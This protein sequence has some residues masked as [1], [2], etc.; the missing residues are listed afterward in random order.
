LPTPRIQRRK[1]PK[2]PRVPSDEELKRLRAIFEYG[3]AM[4]I[5]AKA[6][7]AHVRLP[8]EL[9]VRRPAAATEKQTRDVVLEQMDRVIEARVK[10]RLK[11]AGVPYTEQRP[12]RW[13]S[14]RDRAKAE[15]RS[16]AGAPQD[17]AK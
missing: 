2:R 9:R 8:A 4:A 3:R 15:E 11:V 6:G 12:Y 10:A 14:E 17:A 16:N 5:A 13:W 7:L 1:Q